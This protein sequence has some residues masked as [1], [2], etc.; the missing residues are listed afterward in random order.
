MLA[1]LPAVIG[2][3]S[4]AALAYWGQYAHQAPEIVIVVA[5]VAAIISLVLAWRNT[6]YVAHRVGQLA[7]RAREE[8]TGPHGASAD[9]LDEI[10]RTGRVRMAR[11]TAAERR[12]GEMEALLNDLTSQLADGMR[13]VQLPLH[14]LLDSP[15]GE[16]NENQ[17]EIL[18]SARDAAEAAEVELRQVRKF[19]DLER[20]QVEMHTRSV[21]LA[22]LL[23][24]VLAIAEARAAKRGVTI[25][26]SISPSAPRA[27]VDP[28]H[29][30]EAVTIA[31]T[32]VVDRA[33][34]GS[35]LNVDAAEQGPGT[36][37]IRV[38]GTGADAAGSLPMRLAERLIRAQGGSLTEGSGELRIELRAESL[39]STSA[40]AVG[41]RPA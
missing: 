28:M 40:T 34:A 4:V 25:R 21:G 30:Q 37:G 31:L 8:P 41:S 18:Q 5:A 16:L 17:E 7:M 10:E 14:I 11:V 33:A 23:R 32:H 13:E 15:F 24:P 27:S 35:E 6:R 39:R 2:V 1:V 9:E 26:S 12:T 3:F 29:A 38:T 19:L 20:G 22:E 36:I